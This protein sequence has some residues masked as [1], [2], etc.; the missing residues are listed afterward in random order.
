MIEETKSSSLPKIF[1]V[2]FVAHIIAN[3]TYC[4]MGLYLL[5][6]KPFS[7][8]KIYHLRKYLTLSTA[9]AIFSFVA[10]FLFSRV[11][12]KETVRARAS[13]TMLLHLG[14]FTWGFLTWRKLDPHCEDQNDVIIIMFH[15]ATVFFHGIYFVLYCL[16]ELRHPGADW[17]VAPSFTQHSPVLDV[18]RPGLPGTATAKLPTAPG[19]TPFPTTMPPQLHDSAAFYVPVSNGSSNGQPPK[20]SPFHSP[21]QYSHAPESLQGIIARSQS[22]QQQGHSVPK[23]IS[24]ASK[25]PMPVD[26]SRFMSTP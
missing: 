4:G 17:T 13:A 10:Y 1:L 26:A 18:R 23:E 20:P 5:S 6:F 14:F 21:N 19:T 7:C 8:E 22:A 25:A 12:D 16:H 3:V 15:Q 9:F 2:L 11:K 24:D